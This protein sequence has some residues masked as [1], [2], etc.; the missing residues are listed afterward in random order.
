MAQLAGAASGPNKKLVEA[1]LKAMVG[2][3]A[4][5]TKNLEKTS[6]HQLDLT[7]SGGA[8]KLADAFS[9]FKDILTAPGAQ[10]MSTLMAEIS[11]QTGEGSAKAYVAMLDL[12]NSTGGQFAIKTLSDT[13]NGILNGMTKVTNVITTI[14]NQFEGLKEKLEEL[15]GEWDEKLKDPLI[16]DSPTIQLPGVTPPPD[17]NPVLPDRNGNIILPG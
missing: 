3:G 12:M 4:E 14:S 11:N 7:K 2:L 10:T 8:Q 5:G 16:I 1:M 17:A 6:E 15:F 13:L 9:L